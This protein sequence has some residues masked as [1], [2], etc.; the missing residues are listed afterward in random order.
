MVI[1]CREIRNTKP[2]IYK[3]E[4]KEENGKLLVCRRKYKCRKQ[5]GE[6]PNEWSGWK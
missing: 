5:H 1:A 4:D 6:V 2:G 3:K